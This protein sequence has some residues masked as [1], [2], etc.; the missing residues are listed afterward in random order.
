MPTGILFQK[1]LRCGLICSEFICLLYWR[2]ELKMSVQGFHALLPYT[3][4]IICYNTLYPI[5]L[6]LF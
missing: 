6:L 3:F 1:V 4:V 2:L 5:V